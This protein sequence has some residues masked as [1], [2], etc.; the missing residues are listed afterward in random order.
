MSVDNESV[1]AEL[2]KR[3][4]S[5]DEW[6]DSRFAEKMLEYE[7]SKVPALSIMVT[8]GD[9]D[10]AYPVFIIGSTAAAL[11][12]KVSLFFTFYGLSL[13]KKKV[14][15]KVTALGNTAMPMKMPFGPEWFRGIEWNIPYLIQTNVP[16]F[17]TLATNL[18]KQTLKQKGVATIAELRDACVEF[19]VEIMACQMTVD[20][21]GWKKED[22]FEGVTDW[23]GAATYLSKAKDADVTLFI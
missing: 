1:E 19:E 8:K 13:L 12:W 20:L 17:D 7:S 3:D 14:D 10:W 4:M 2:E 5:L 15:P 11:G 22:F 23:A 9:L 6:F 16:G 18:M 21:F